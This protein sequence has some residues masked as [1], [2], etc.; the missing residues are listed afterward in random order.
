M[1]EKVCMQMQNR[2]ILVHQLHHEKGGS[3]YVCVNTATEEIICIYRQGQWFDCK[4][5][6]NAPF[7]RLRLGNSSFGQD[8]I[9]FWTF[10]CMS[11]I[12]SC[13]H[14][15]QVYDDKENIIGMQTE[16][17]FDLNRMWPNHIPVIKKKNRKGQGGCLHWGTCFF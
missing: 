13:C 17:I 3:V 10:D 15:A 6:L 9:T 12:M 7:L 5:I 14:G 4:M 2:R 1:M 11:T 16:M 8:S